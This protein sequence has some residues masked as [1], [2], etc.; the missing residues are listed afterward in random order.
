M[1][2]KGLAVIFYFLFKEFLQTKHFLFL[3]FSTFKQMR[4][5]YLNVNKLKKMFCLKKFFEWRM[6]YHNY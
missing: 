6:K 4:K 2:T 3:S 1:E 5:N